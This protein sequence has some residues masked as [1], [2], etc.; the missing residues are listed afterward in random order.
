MH[1]ESIEESRQPCPPAPKIKPMKGSG[2]AFCAVACEQAGGTAACASLHELRRLSAQLLT[3]QESERQRIATDL[4]DGLGQSLTLIRL[5]LEDVTGLLAA[6]AHSEA[7]ESLQKLKLKV[8]DAFGELRRVAMDLRPSTLDDLGILAT[9]SWFFREFESACRGIKI[10]KHLLVQESNIPVP[11]KIT[12]FRILQEAVSNIV[13]HAKADHIRVSLMKTGDV[14][15][16]SVEDNG[17]GFDPAGRDNYC[18]LDKGLGLV[19]MKERA[20][21]SGGTYRIESAVG[22]GTRIFVSWSCG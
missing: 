4:H 1:A 2:Q 11:L 10:E 21:F 18:P 12:I 5:A 15:H 13:K 16:L 22:K 14:L 9:L 6:N 17:Q 8:Q 19:S 3:I 20:K 7:G